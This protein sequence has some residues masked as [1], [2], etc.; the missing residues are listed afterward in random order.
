[1]TCECSHEPNVHI[2][3]GSAGLGGCVKC[4]C[5]AY[6]PVGMSLETADVVGEVR[7]WRA[8]K[9]GGTTEH[10]RLFS[11]VHDT[12][13]PNREWNV[14][15]CPNRSRHAADAVIPVETCSCGF[16]AAKDMAQ[17]MQLGYAKDAAY[18]EAPRVIGEVGQVGKIIPGSAGY[19]AQY[20]RVVRLLLP[21][22]NWSYAEA[23]AREYRVPVGLANNYT[24]AEAAEEVQAS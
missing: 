3:L 19:R 5:H 20:A 4:D 7:A 24:G 1:M 6:T 15:D 18:G 17:L 16:Y 22:R 23:L 14:A 21:Y 13:W 8:W 12:Y 9:I 2:P 10:P 11:V